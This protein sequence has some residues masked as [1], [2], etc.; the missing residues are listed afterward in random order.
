MTK[1]L[2]GIDDGDDYGLKVF[3]ACHCAPS[4][5]H[6]STSS[7]IYTTVSDGSHGYTK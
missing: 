1:S 3:Y 2:I 4:L 7:V 5:Q 6:F